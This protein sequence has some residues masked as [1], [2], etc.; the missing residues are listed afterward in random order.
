M[1][2]ATRRLPWRRPQSATQTQGCFRHTGRMPLLIWWNSTSCRRS[3]KSVRPS[4]MVKYFL[5]PSSHCGEERRGGSEGRGR[6]RRQQSPAGTHGDHQVVFDLQLMRQGQDEALAVLL[7]LPDQ[8]HA[9]AQTG[10]H[11]YGS[12]ALP[13]NTGQTQSSMWCY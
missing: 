2:N 5:P 12:P 6:R 11:G 10:R 1:R 9:A 4:S 8:E 3:I 13:P 7:A